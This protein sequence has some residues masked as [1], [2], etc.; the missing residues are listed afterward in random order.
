MKLQ[1]ARIWISPSTV[2]LRVAVVAKDESWVRFADLRIPRDVV[3]RELL[4]LDHDWV[5]EARSQDQPLPGMP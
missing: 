2:H 5:A 3:V 1:L 4:D